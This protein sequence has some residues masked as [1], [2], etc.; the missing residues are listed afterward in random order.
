MKA[1]YTGPCFAA[2]ST[3]GL[4][5]QDIRRILCVLPV[6][7]DAGI[8][9]NDSSNKTESSGETSNVFAFAGGWRCA[10]RGGGGAAWEVD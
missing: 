8:T 10:G 5:D 9:S 6:L 3:I 2:H 1:K 7:Q 4:T